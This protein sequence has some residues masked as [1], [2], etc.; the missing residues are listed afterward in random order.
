VPRRE[1]AVVAA[2]VA[3]PPR[4]RRRL[5]IIEVAVA[6]VNLDDANVVAAGAVCVRY[7]PE[8]VGSAVQSIINQY[9]SVLPLTPAAMSEAGSGPVCFPEHSNL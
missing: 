7:Q 5:Q 2:A 1:T 6:E 8:R 4:R 9:S 3:L